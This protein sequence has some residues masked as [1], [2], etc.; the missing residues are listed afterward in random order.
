M[1]KLDDQVAV[2]G[3]IPGRKRIAYVLQN[4]SD[5]MLIIVDDAPGLRQDQMRVELDI[6]PNNGVTWN[7][8]I[9]AWGFCRSGSRVN[10]VEASMVGGINVGAACL[11]LDSTN[12]FRSGCTN[13]Q[14]MLLDR[15]TTSEL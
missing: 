10:L 11:S 3:Q 2:V 4:S 15:S 5:V 12:D 1:I 8:A 7:K 13:T 9:E 14:A 6:D